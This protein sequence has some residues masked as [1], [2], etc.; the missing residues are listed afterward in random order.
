M[1]LEFSVGG[2]FFVPV[3]KYWVFAMNKK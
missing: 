3:L 2:T 1:Y